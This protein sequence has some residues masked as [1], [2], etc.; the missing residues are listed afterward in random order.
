MK[1][2]VI[3]GMGVAGACVA[4]Q[5][6]FRGVPFRII[7]R[8][9]GGSSRVAAGLVN[10]VSGKNCTVPDRYAADF[11]EAQEFYRNIEAIL[12]T[13][14]W[15]ALEVIRLVAAKDA[16]KLEKKMRDGDA[17][18]WVVGEMP[19]APWADCKAYLLHGAARLD[20]PGFLA[21]SRAFF[22]QQGCLETG[23]LDEAV[24]GSITLWCEGAEGLIAG[25]PLPWRQRCAKGEIL[26]VHAPQWQQSR[27][28]T[29]RGWLVPIGADQYKVGA[30]YDWDRVDE[31]TT[32]EGLAYLCQ[33]AT[34]LGGP[35][36]SILAHE[37]GI[38]PI[39]R[40]SQP[41][42]GPIGGDVFVFNGLG[43]K[44]SLTAPWA[45]GQLV[46]HWLDGDEIDLRLCARHYFEN[47]LPQ[48]S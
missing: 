14:L 39:I 2:I 36:F 17:S 26:T 22:S 6:W 9:S 40:K 42:A 31:I 12:Q 41:V 10:P 32:P 16:A 25:H 15:F 23:V 48:K 7:D 46:K 44:G 5:L 8:G 30:T 20:V 29:G 13:Q 11:A 3:A 28:I 37:A 34:E 43:S 21:K 18:Q 33:L 24:T 35:D 38:R 27:M 47:L 45:A 19:D 1:P 4:W